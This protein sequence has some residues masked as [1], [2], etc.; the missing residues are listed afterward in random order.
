MTEATAETTYPIWAVWRWKLHW[1]ILLG[2]VLGALVGLGL[3]SSVETSAEL[4]D[5]ASFKTLALIAQMFINGLKML[6]VPLVAA[7][8]IV[9]M[10]GIGKRPGFAR[11]GG[12]TLLYYL[13]TSLIAVLIGITLVNV[14]APGVSDD[15]FVLTQ[16]T[17]DQFSNEQATIKKKVG[18]KEGSDF[19]DVFLKMIP[20]NIVAA[21]ANGQLLGLIV[22]SLLF[23]YFMARLNDDKRVVMEQFWGGLY[24][25]AIS[26]TNLVLAFA[27]IG[28]AALIAK[29]L[30]DNVV[31]LG[32]DGRLDQ[33]IGMIFM[34]AVTTILALGIH[35][36][37]VMPLILK[38]VAGVSPIA[39]LKAM[40]PAIVTAFSTASSAATLP[41]TLDCVETRSRVSNRTA[42]FVLPLGATVNMDG[43]AL[44]ECVAAL[45]I[46]QLYGIDLGMADQFFIIMVALLT[47]VG[48]AGVPSASL[49]AIVIILQA[50]GVPMEGL[51]IILVVD[52]ILD[53]CRTSVN[54]WG[55]S[56]G[57]VVIAKSEGEDQVLVPQAPNP[58][59][60][61]T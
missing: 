31:A 54:I 42:S 39:H 28:I 3:A 15:G 7:S 13:C 36:L 26:V 48:V 58:D 47:S 17:T 55:D 16:E 45:F 61:A 44:F 4:K 46:A 20:S 34:F 29:T 37:I 50:V 21:A 41:V 43:T 9:A 2:I 53:M 10:G 59:T 35:A 40:M 27:P 22:V 56:C 30:A 12:E 24:D 52:R 11:M 14:I 60:A 33:L 19:F 49:V 18:D 6:I 38:F 23:G 51:A 8:L 57:A 25:I 5:S 32:A 1:Q